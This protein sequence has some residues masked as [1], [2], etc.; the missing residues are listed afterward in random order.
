MTTVNETVKQAISSHSALARHIFKAPDSA[1]GF[2]WGSVGTSVFTLLL[3]TAGA[4]G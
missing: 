1:P 4:Q 3:N 2:H